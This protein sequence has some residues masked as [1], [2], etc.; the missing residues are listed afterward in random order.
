[1]KKTLKLGFGRRPYNFLNFFLTISASQV[2]IKLCAKNQL[3]MCHG[4]GLSQAVLGLNF[5][6]GLVGS[7]IKD[8]VN[9]ITLCGTLVETPILSIYAINKQ[10]KNQDR[11]ESI[12]TPLKCLHFVFLLVPEKVRKCHCPTKLKVSKV[13]FFSI[14]IIT[15]F[16]GGKLFCGGSII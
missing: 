8:V 7:I 9:Q 15:L 14:F 12:I 11:M 6:L 10:T 3:P 2:N 4:S 1:M 13:N 5:K 16:V